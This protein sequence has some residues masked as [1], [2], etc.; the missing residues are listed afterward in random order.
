MTVRLKNSI[1]PGYLKDQLTLVAKDYR[2]PTISVMVEGQILPAITAPP[3]LF[4]G[5]MEPGDKVTKNLVVKGKAP[6]RITGI[7][8]NADGFQFTLPET[9]KRLHLLPVNFSAGQTAG[10]IIESL[11]IQT[12]AGAGITVNCTATAQVRS[13]EMLVQ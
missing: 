3:S 9:A 7:K 1:D 12:D 2:L 13:D 4:L 11:E 8:C 6:F 5:V 10:D